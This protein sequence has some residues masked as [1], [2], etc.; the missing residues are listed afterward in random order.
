MNRKDSRHIHDS[1]TRACVRIRVLDGF[2][3]Q[4]Q[5]YF[6]NLPP[7]HAESEILSAIIYGPELSP[8]PAQNLSLGID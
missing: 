6:E 3:N 7:C 2:Y 5:L 8:K 4:Y 1:M